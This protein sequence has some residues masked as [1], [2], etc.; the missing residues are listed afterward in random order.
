ML[1]F[2]VLIPLA[3]FVACQS[4]PT[5]IP[6]PPTAASTK[7]APATA[8]APATAPASAKVTMPVPAPDYTSYN[9]M[10]VPTKP[11]L[12][13]K[14]I[15]PSLYFTA[16]QLTAIRARVQAGGYYAQLWD[17][18]QNEVSTL[19]ALA[20]EK[21]DYSQR[22]WMAKVLA[23]HYLMTGEKKSRDV[24][25]KALMMAFDGIPYE[26]IK[27]EDLSSLKIG[28]IYRGTWIQNYSESYDWLYND[29]TPEQNKTIREKLA[30]EAQWWFENFIGK[31]LD[32][33]PRPHNHRSKLAWGVG[34]LALTLSSDL[35]A[36][37]WLEWSLAQSNTVT[38]YMF[39]ADGIYREGGHY[40]VYSLV[41][42]IP[43]LYHY[44]N[45][46]GVDLFP[47]FQPAFE[48]P[49]QTR[50]SHGWLAPIEDSYLKPVPTHLVAA[51]YRNSATKLSSS[52]KLGN[53]LQWGY[54]TTDLWTRNY[55]GASN[56]FTLATEE[57]IL[58]DATI[59][60]VAPDASP[61]QLLEG[62]QV[63]FR[64]AWSRANPN[65]RF[66]LFHGVPEADNHYHYDQ[67]SF[68]LEGGGTILASD[69]GY[70]PDG[71][72]DKKRTEWYLTP[73]AHN[74]VT[75]N[76]Q[77][78]I[79]AQTNVANETRYFLDTPAFAFVEKRAPYPTGAT[80]RR[81]I[82]F[83]AKDYFVVADYLN[84]KDTTTFDL[85][86]HGR[87][88]LQRQGNAAAWTTEEDKFG[89]S[90]KLYAFFSPANATFTQKQNGGFNFFGKEEDLFDYLQVTQKANDARLMQILVPRAPKDAAPTFQ[91][92]SKE[93]VTAAQISNGGSVDT[94]LA[95]SCDANCPPA[96][97]N[98]MTAA[99]A[100]AWTRAQTDRVVG[101]AMKD[102]TTISFDNQTLL[103]TDR[104]ATLTLDLTDAN[105][106]VGAVAKPNDAMA[107]KF[108]L[109]SSKSVYRVTLDGKEIPFTIADAFALFTI[110]AS[111]N[112]EIL[113]Q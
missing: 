7:V 63:A 36:S 23:F 53:V 50:M 31:P 1:R 60:A 14:E 80:I 15:H 96:S 101:Y 56:D 100:F 13:A 18:I 38:Q 86:L 4:A 70:A 40:Y 9:G 72:S 110:N 71:Y 64:D 33:S 34:T 88:K 55:T 37:K 62:G 26:G 85:Y 10:V 29:L 27:K 22:P 74:L 95:Q 59:Q 84:A 65:S 106:V 75:A 112:L 82:A 12:P 3:V 45:V 6:A 113:L 73:Q 111:G 43:F 76:G 79:D 78:P 91:D 93:N 58:Y 54:F 57:F 8:A 21:T 83:I 98:R 42:L 68:T 11:I 103:T 108:A 109:P 52:A 87:G 20:P 49:L 28:D 5:A 77:G 47:A 48:W 25:I 67:L 41:N 39:S 17:I 89:P 97:A 44:K 69:A 61:N 35:R 16:E 90:A 92:L 32:I 2:F 107:I 19:H 99:A 105:R 30:R 102:G 51:A 66:L 24:A 94:F 81:D 104:P 46:S